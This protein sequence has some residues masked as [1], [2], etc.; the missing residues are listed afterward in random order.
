V[1]FEIPHG[2]WLAI[3]YLGIFLCAELA[4]VIM[5]TREYLQSLLHISDRQIVFA[6]TNN[7]P[8]T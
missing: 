5:A 1:N 2:D 6:L 3:Y 7:A 4:F 8:V